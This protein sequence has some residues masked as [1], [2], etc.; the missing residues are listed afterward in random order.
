MYYVVAE[1]FCND[2]GLRYNVAESN[3]IDSEILAESVAESY[4]RKFAGDDSVRVY[5]VYIGNDSS[6]YY[7]R[8][9]Y[10]YVGE[11]WNL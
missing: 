6:G 4:V 7:N 9:G 1:R 11:P 5:V 10:S 8:S 3:R 2:T